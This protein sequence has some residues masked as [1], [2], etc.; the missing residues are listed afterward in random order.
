MTTA[1]TQPPTPDET[2]IRRVV[3]EVTSDDPR[4]LAVYWFGSRTRGEALEGSD[5][6]LAALFTEPVDVMELLGLEDRIERAL[7]TPVDLL[8]LGKAGAFLALDAIRGERIYCTDPTRCDEFDLYVLRRAGDLEPF[9]R[10]RRRLALTPPGP[11]KARRTLDRATTP[12]SRPAR[13]DEPS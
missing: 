2:T 9:E 10:E 1:P 12:P 7:G 4:V 5:V 13:G 8:D 11:R 6:D 3:A